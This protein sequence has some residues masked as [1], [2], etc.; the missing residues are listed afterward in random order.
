MTTPVP[1]TIPDTDAVLRQ[2]VLSLGTVAILT[3]P[4][5]YADTDPPAGYDPSPLAGAESTRGPAVLLTNRGGRPNATGALLDLTYQVRCYGATRLAAQEL[6]RALLGALHS[7]A[8]GVIRSVRCTVV[9]QHTPLPEL[10]WH[11]FLSTWQLTA[12]IL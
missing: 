1:R 7:R 3:G 6:D 5:V 11:M 10:Q 9:G 4:R 12:V 8:R 2:L